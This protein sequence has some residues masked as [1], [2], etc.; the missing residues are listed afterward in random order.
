MERRFAAI[1]AA[2]V[3]GYSRLIREDEEGT[4][5]A[6][7]NLPLILLKRRSPNILGAS[8]SSWAKAAGG[9]QRADGDRVAA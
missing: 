1:L 6:F 9:A 7:K 8:P 4:L 5:T 3:V 2:D